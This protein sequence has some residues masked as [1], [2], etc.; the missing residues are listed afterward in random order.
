[1]SGHRQRAWWGWGFEDAK[2][3][4]A[5]LAP[6]VRDVLG[7][8]LSGEVE[9]PVGLGSI[10]LPEARFSPPE[11][12]EGWSTDPRDRIEHAYGRSFPDTVRAFRGRIDHAPDAV[13]FAR[14]EEAIEARLEWAAREDVAVVPFGGGTSV[15]GGVEPKVPADRLGVVS[16]DLS[17]MNRVLEVDDGSRAGRGPGGV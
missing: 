4:P 16:L 14:D 10:A 7:F 12:I 9:Q 1:M 17:H 15:V 3:D 13:V 8:P 5:A 11:G 2:L 6:L